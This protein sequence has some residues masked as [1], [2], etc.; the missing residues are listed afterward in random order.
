MMDR[1]VSAAFRAIGTTVALAS[2]LAGGAGCDRGS[3]TPAAPAQ[4]ASESRP[5]PEYSIPQ[6][7][8]RQ[9]PEVASF[10]EQ[11]L[12]VCLANDYAGYR[13][14][15][16]RRVEPETQARF[17][18]IYQAIRK[19]QVESITPR[20]LRDLADEAFVVVSYV[21]VVPEA[22]EPATPDASP[23]SGAAPASEGPPPAA[24]PQRSPGFRLRKDNR[25][26]AILVFREDDAWRMAPAPAAL[27]PRE[28]DAAA[29]SAASQPAATQPDYP[30]ETNAD[31]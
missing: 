26:I 24:A 4:T 27:Q 9:Y 29:G 17:E 6:D 5:L 22:A 18:R 11:F 3:A 16:S 8:R 25:R 1:P 12:E 28:P 31:D 15:V 14:L 30:W 19:V 21:D 2:L 23:T 7:L 20:R 13:R 10:V